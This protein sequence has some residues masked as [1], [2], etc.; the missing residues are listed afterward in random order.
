MRKFVPYLQV[1]NVQKESGQSNPVVSV[2][3]SV[4]IILYMELLLMWY[5]CIVYIF[6]YLH[7][8]SDFCWSNLHESEEYR[9]LYREFEK[10]RINL[11]LG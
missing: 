4:L 2:V 10:T 7:Q 9:D 6:L 1:Q 11:Y 8:Q 3:L 5:S